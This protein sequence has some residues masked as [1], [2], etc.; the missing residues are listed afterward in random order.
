MG[1]LQTL[2]L[3]RFIVH[4]YQLH[5]S[6]SVEETLCPSGGGAFGGNDDSVTAALHWTLPCTDFDSMWESLYYDEPIKERLLQYA[7]TALRFADAQ[8][9]PT[10][11]TLNRVILLHGP[12]GTGKTTLSKALAQKLAIRLSKRFRCGQFIEINSHSLFSKYFSESG[13]LVLQMF[14]KISEFV[15]DPD[16][17]VC[18]LIDEIESLTA[19]RRGAMNGNEPSDLVRV[20]NAVLTQIDQ[21]KRRPNVLLMATSNLIDA[22]DNAF[23]DRA[24][25][26]IH[27]KLPSS[28]ASYHVLQSTVDE[29]IRVSLLE[30]TSLVHLQKS[31]LMSM[32]RRAVEGGLSCRTLRKLAFL[33]YSNMS[34]STDIVRLT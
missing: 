27:V 2:D 34:E 20:V 23:I 24:D 5:E 9:D 6:G 3:V 19:A 28:T 21:L 13:K 22:I 8:V 17:F 11:I 1:V 33:A 7:Q 16:A 32:S 4:V 14:K 10:I 31:S 29:L 25:I 15:E 30:K 26:K 18:V 12:P